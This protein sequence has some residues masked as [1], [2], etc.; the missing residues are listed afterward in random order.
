M[1]EESLPFGA[2]VFFAGGA[3]GFLSNYPMSGAPAMTA[4]FLG[5]KS[6]FHATGDFY[7]EPMELIAAE[8]AW[9]TRSSGFYRNPTR[10]A[11][12]DEIARWMHTPGEPPEIFGEGKL[13]DRI[14]AKL[15]GEKA[16]SKCRVIIDCMN[17]CLTFPTIRPIERKRN[18]CIIV[19]AHLRI[20]AGFSIM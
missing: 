9:N 13:F 18:N 16:A 17:G 2:F 3:D 12:V 15:Y 14:C 4:H 20:Y 7:V 8:Y 6:I 1:T 10:Q 5:A 19:V 11:D